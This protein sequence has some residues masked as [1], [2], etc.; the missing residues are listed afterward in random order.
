[1]RILSKSQI[2]TFMQC[3]RKWKYYYI[4]E[5]PSIAS[6]QQDRGSLVHKKIEEFYKDIP[7][8]KYDED[9]KHFYAFE[10]QRLKDCSDLKFF[11]PVFQELKITNDKLGM[12]GIIDAVY[13]NHKDHKL[14]IIDWKTGHF[15]INDLDDYRIELAVYK[16]LL[17]K[18]DKIKDV[19][20]GWWGIYFTDQNKLFFEAVDTKYIKRMYQIVEN[21]RK[22]I[23]EED[24]RKKPSFWC[25]WCQ[26]KDKCG[27]NNVNI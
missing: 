6:P 21:I 1:M 24:F 12:R 19:E 14:I 22:K 10:L 4:D 16:E 8:Q 15:N 27:G 9:L 2:K 3:P 7:N 11:Y 23:E 18:S 25:R 20:V 5:I 26:F 13:L 17:E